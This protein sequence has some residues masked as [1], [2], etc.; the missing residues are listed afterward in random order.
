MEPAATL[1]G[2][3]INIMPDIQRILSYKKPQLLTEWK[4]L[5]HSGFEP[6]TVEHMRAALFERFFR[7]LLDSQINRS[8][9]STSSQAADSEA[10]H[11]KAAITSPPTASSL[12]SFRQAVSAPQSPIPPA[13]QSNWIQ[14]NTRL[15]KLE[16]MVQD[17]SHKFQALDR[18]AEG[19]QR[20]ARQLDLVLYNLPEEA[21]EEKDDDAIAT[22]VWRTACAATAPEFTIKVKRLGARSKGHRPVLVTFDTMDD[23]HTFLKYANTL[24]PTGV[25]WDDYLTRQ[26][27]S[28]RRSLATDFQALKTK[29]YK[30]FYRGSVLKYRIAD[31]TH[32][33]SMGQALKAP[34]V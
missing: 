2:D 19:V 33:C 6:S 34:K 28:E 21:E 27:Q 29:G 9:A 31:K 32:N 3:D 17:H 11:S 10:T 16:S 13:L 14:V 7:D 22:L 23:K 8:S 5:D 30:P 26:Q 1:S 15:A 12:K 18:K 24:K 4:K 25:K 20:R